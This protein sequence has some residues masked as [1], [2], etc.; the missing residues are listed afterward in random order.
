MRD[1][2]QYLSGLDRS[3]EEL[4]PDINESGWKFTAVG[5]NQI[6]FG[7]G[8]VRGEGASAVKALI[9]A[10]ESGGPFKAMF[11]FLERV[12]LRALNKRA[13]EALLSAGA[14]DSFGHRA[15]LCLLYT[16]PSPRDATLS[17]MPS[18]A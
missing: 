8:A 17:R 13:V 5:K 9:E 2:S 6:R 12:D 14:M 1:I 11:D 4:P 18:Y 3:I 16:S 7:L 10:R 15:Q